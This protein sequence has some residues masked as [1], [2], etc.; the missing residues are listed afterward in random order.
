M[1]RV[2]QIAQA[3]DVET[4]GPRAHF[5]AVGELGAG[6]FSPSLEQR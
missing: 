5:E 4:D 6:P 3:F 2:A 1:D